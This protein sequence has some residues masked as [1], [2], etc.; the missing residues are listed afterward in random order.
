MLPESDEPLRLADGTLV[1]PDRVVPVKRDV[2]RLVEIPTN[3]DAQNI[4]LQTRRKLSE[5]PDVPRTL[6]AVSVVISYTLFGLDDDEICIATNL[7]K[8][9]LINLRDQPAYTMMYNNII[10]SILEAEAT[11]VRDIFVQSSRRAAQRFV[12]TLDEPGALGLAAAGQVLDRA[13]MRPVDI[14]EHRHRVDGGLV[15]EVIHKDE[16]KQ[17]PIIDMGI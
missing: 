16:K 13:G 2:P 15:I 3:R 9:Q 6:N 17:P 10:K 5:L 7:N 11:Q 8:D 12:D 14:V 4:V 1:Y